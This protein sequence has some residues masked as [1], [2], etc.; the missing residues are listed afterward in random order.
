LRAL[1]I[2]P[3]GAIGRTEEKEKRWKTPS[4]STDTK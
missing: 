1:K 2:C 3:I 4:S